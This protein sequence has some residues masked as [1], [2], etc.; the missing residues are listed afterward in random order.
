MFRDILNSL[1]KEAE[2]RVTQVEEPKRSKDPIRSTGN[3]RYGSLV[4][5]IKSNYGNYLSGGGT[6]EEVKQQ[7]EQ[8]L[9]ASI[10]KGDFQNN[11]DALR[12]FKTYING[13]KYGDLVKL[14]E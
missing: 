13:K 14:R 4:A 8:I 1:K 12:G 11:P 7:L 9:R 5:W 2:K 10:A 6:D 3:R